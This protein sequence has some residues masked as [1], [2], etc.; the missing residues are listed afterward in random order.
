MRYLTIERRRSYMRCLVKMKVYIEDP[1]YGDTRINGCS[2][3]KIG[4]LKNGKTATFSIT[5]DAVKVFVV[6]D[7]LTRNICN[8]FCT[9]EAGDEDVHLS[10][11][12]DPDW[13]SGNPFRFDGEG[14]AQVRA[15][16]SRVRKFGIVS[17]IIAF[18]FALALGVGERFLEDYIETRPR[19]FTASG[20]T[21]TL[22][23]TFKE[24]EH[25][26][27]TCIFASEEAAVLARKEEFSL[28][29]GLE[30]CTLDEYGEM[31]ILATPHLDS[32]PLNLAGN[33][34]WFEYDYTNP[35]SGVDYN[36]YTCLY[37]A[38]DAFWTIQF[39]ADA[40]HALRLR[41]DFEKWAASVR[42]E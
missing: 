16:R 37:K 15:N 14:D 42:F 10:G 9:I 38:G 2:C 28:L 4:T 3:T 26:E 27:V 34:T 13:L 6:P 33:Y 17:L 1:V 25:P 5:N 20:M 41:P 29:E 32:A 19:N 40:D 12:V 11:I 30:Y 35:E 22:D 39:A 31:V 18:I 23:N 24:T 36:Y 7:K 21:I 8:D